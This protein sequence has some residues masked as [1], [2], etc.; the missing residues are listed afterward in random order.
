MTLLNA[1]PWPRSI[2]MSLQLDGRSTPQT[3]TRANESDTLGPGRVSFGFR[4]PG[5]KP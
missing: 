4:G 5:G 1:D 3:I 2:D